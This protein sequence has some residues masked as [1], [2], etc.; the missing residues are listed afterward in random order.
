[1]IDKRREKAS[2]GKEGVLQGVGRKSES[3]FVC[4]SLDEI[5]TPL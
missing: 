1:M 4:R 2:K 5:Q 3:G